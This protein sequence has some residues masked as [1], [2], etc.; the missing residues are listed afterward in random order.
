M[1]INNVILHVVFL[2][3]FFNHS[4]AFGNAVGMDSLQI[5]KKECSISDC[6]IEDQLVFICTGAYAYAYHSRSDCPGL[7]NCK[8]QVNY[9][10]SYT[11]ASNLG[12]VPCCKCWANVSGR[13][14]DDNPSYGGG[15]SDGD[16]LALAALAIISTSAIILSNDLYI[17]P[18]LSFKKPLLGNGS[19]NYQIDGRAGIAFGFR[20]TF[21]KSALEYGAS[22]IKYNVRQSYGYGYYAYNTFYEQWGGHLN[23]VHEVFRQKTPHWLYAYTGPTINGI[24]N[25]GFGG[26]IGAYIKIGDRL[27][28]DV[29]YELTTQSNQLQAGLIFTYQK[30][31]FWQK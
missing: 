2:F 22:Y 17:Y 29:R 14:R 11:A 12:R 18:L 16:A 23:Y 5:N 21:R 15:G 19:S 10:D 3:L 24:Y 13:C 4:S 28:L 27:K 9:T 30:K 31:Y 8:G 6:L 20:K 25:F 7:N 26:I 1:K